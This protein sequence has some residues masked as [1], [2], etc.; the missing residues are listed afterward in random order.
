[1]KKLILALVLI[2]GVGLLAMLPASMLY[3]KVKGQVPG[4]RLSHISGTVWYG[5]AK[6][7]V[8]QRSFGEISWRFMPLEL[9]SAR[10]GWKVKVPEFNSELGYA[11]HPWQPA[12]VGALSFNSSVADLVPLAPLLSS[13]Q[14]EIEA[15][16]FSLDTS[17]CED[18][19]GT[20]RL[21]GAQ[22]LGL[23]FGT[24]VGDLA[25][26][27]ASYQLTLSNRDAE[28]SLAGVA[29]LTIDGQY[30]LQGKL[31]TEKQEIKQQLAALMG[32]N[33]K[34]GSFAFKQQGRLP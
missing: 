14:S 27:N 17:G 13:L 6:A 4:V 9:L 18:S 3:D 22:A 2:Y 7:V 33:E 20:I 23:D 25:C 24:V 12:V 5:S 1:M 34:Q 15:E 11:L 29:K 16:L 32:G 8:Q 21:R 26:E 31:T 19:H 30:Q 28:I 10:L